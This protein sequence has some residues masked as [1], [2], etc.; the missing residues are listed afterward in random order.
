MTPREQKLYD[1]L[2]ALYKDAKADID[3]LNR[4]RKACDLEP[5]GLD[6]ID[7]AKAILD[8]FRQ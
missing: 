3:Q 8:E 2:E 1:A 5:C 6:S 7:L 4:H